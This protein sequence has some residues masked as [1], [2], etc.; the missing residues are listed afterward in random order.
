LPRLALNWDRPHQCLAKLSSSYLEFFLWVGHLGAARLG[1]AHKVLSVFTAWQLA[2]TWAN[3]PRERKRE[4][5]WLLLP[6]LG[7][8]MVSIFQHSVHY[9]GHTYSILERGYFCT[10]GDTMRQGSFI[11]GVVP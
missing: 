8:Y 11:C 7:I 5:K 2:F 9:P 3:D 1:L 10:G 4:A 6:T